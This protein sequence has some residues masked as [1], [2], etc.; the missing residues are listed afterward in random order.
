MPLALAVVES[1]LLSYYDRFSLASLES[2]ISVGFI[3]LLGGAP[4]KKNY[5]LFIVPYRFR[6]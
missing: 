2:D 4:K 1:L 3:L 5:L 6:L